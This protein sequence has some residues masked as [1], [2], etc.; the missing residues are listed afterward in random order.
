MLVLLL[1]DWFIVW[2]IEPLLQVCGA[3]LHIQHHHS[4]G[5]HY[6]IAEGWWQRFIL[7]VP[8]SQVDSKQQLGR[9]VSQGTIWCTPWIPLRGSF[10]KV[11]IL[12]FCIL[13]SAQIAL[14]SIGGLYP[15]NWRVFEVNPCKHR[16]TLSARERNVN[17]SCRIPISNNS[18]IK[19]FL[20]TC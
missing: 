11:P 17:A 7:F 10:V 6:A 19:E 13:Y 5:A 15:F 1:M 9:V 3:C 16:P 14:C 18:T 4:F 12:P 8:T 2:E 20:C